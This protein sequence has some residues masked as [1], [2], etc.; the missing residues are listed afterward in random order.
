MPQN[1]QEH[2]PLQLEDPANKLAIQE[3]SQAHNELLHTMGNLTLITGKLNATL[4]NGSWSDKRP[5][6]IKYSKLDLNRYF[7]DVDSWD[8]Q[9]IRDR[10]GACWQGEADL[11]LSGRVNSK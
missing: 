6:L 11:A 10:G 2:W 5:E 1:R 8:E 3:K 7:P 4:S 9:A